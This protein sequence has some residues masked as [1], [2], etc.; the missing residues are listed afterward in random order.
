MSKLRSDACLTVPARTQV[1]G[2]IGLQTIPGGKFAV[3]HFEIAVDQFGAAWDAL[4]GEWLPSSGYQPDDR[5]CYEMYLND[6]EQHPEKK[7]IVDIC[8]P[9]RPL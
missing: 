7:L 1:D 6:R 5:M 3:G 2:E 8:E 9:V 4:M